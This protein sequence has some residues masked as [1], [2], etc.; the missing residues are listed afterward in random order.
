MKNFVLNICTKY[1]SGYMKNILFQ[2]PTLEEI[3]V[4]LSPDNLPWYLNLLLK[5]SCLAVNVSWHIHSSVPN[6]EVVKIITFFNNCVVKKQ[7]TENSS[8][9]NLRLIFK[10][11][12]LFQC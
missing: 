9:V 12:K 5:E 6:E 8:K 10:Y 4:D 3:V 1:S 11:G 7:T 2:I